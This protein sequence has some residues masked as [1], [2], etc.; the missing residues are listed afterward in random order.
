MYRM[1]FVEIWGDPWFEGLSPE[2]KLLFFYLITAPRGRRTGAIEVTERKICADTGLDEVPEIADGDHVMFWPEL[3]TYFVPRWLHYQSERGNRENYLTGAR[4]AAQEEPEPVREAFFAVYGPPSEETARPGIPSSPP[5]RKKPRGRR[6][7]T[8]P[9]DPGRFEAVVEAMP[10]DDVKPRP[11]V[12]STDDYL[13]RSLASLPGR[14]GDVTHA[15]VQKLIN[16]LGPEPVRLALEGAWQ[17]KQSPDNPYAWLRA[18]ATR[19]KEE[20]DAAREVS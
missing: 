12:Q 4:K 11:R 2:Q 19:I 1:V 15:G 16:D 8:R 17:G 18:V 14:W 7:P 5:K 9:S 6:E 20:T 3:N 10:K 13:L